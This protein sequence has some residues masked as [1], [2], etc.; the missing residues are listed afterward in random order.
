M[1]F[2]QNSSYRFFKKDLS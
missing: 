1:I 2:Y